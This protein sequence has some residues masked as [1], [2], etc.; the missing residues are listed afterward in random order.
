MVIFLVTL[1]LVVALAYNFALLHML[2]R[3]E[4]F[5][6]DDNPTQTAWLFILFD[7]PLILGS[8]WAIVDT[9]KW[10]VSEPHNIFAVYP[11]VA[12][13]TPL[14]MAAIVVWHLRQRRA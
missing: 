6:P 10:L 5:G 14:I 7:A 13:S 2:L 1:A 11:L 4:N 8:L 9:T 3:R 12:G